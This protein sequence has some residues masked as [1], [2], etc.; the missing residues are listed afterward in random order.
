MGVI[1]LK[2]VQV[3]QDDF[4]FSFEGD[5]HVRKKT[6]FFTGHR[7]PSDA[8]LSPMCRPLP[9]QPLRQIVL[10]PRSFVGTFPMIPKDALQSLG[11]WILAPLLWGSLRGRRVPCPLAELRL[12]TAVS[13][14]FSPSVRHSLT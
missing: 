9:R 2:R 13:L 4:L 11:L 12:T 3:S 8:H 5:T 14:V 1:D 7:P 6:C 10:L